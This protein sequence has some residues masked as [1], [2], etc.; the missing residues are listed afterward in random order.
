M[1]FRK[2]RKRTLL[3]SRSTMIVKADLPNKRCPVWRCDSAW[4]RMYARGWDKLK[5]CS[6][7]CRKGAPRGRAH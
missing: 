7:A 4:R 5:F 3:L 1:I 6:D 2:D